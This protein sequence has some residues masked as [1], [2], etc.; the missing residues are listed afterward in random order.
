MAGLSRAVSLALLLATSAVRAQEFGAGPASAGLLSLGFVTSASSHPGEKVAAHTGFGGEIAY[1]QLFLLSRE[2]SMF[3][4]FGVGAAA[5]AEG[6]DGFSHGRYA[7]SARLS[8]G[9]LG[10]DIGLAREESDGIHRATSYMQL[11]PFLSSGMSWVAFRAAFPLGSGS[12]YSRELGVVFS[13]RL[14]LLLGGPGR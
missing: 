4:A 12:V 13:L 8:L 3:S 10:T 5:Q 14:P 11:A 2:P 7:A 9:I 6:V 1:Q